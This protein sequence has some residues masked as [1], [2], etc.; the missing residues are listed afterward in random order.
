MLTRIKKKIKSK[1][2]SF[3]KVFHLCENGYANKIRNT[4]NIN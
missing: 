1:K 3:V 2:Q 4:N